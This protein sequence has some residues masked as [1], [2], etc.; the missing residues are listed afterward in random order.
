MNNHSIETVRNFILIG[1]TGRNTGKTTLASA[2]IKKLRERSPVN[3][4]KIITVERKGALCP[5]GGVGCGVCSLE[6][7]F[8]LCEE[9]D[10]LSGKDTAQLLM[11]GANRVFLLRSLK[12]AL[13]GAFAVLRGQTGNKILVAESN[14]L[15]TVVKPALF[16]MLTDGSVRPKFSAQAVMKDA[17]LIISAPFTEN[18]LADIFARLSFPKQQTGQSS[19][20]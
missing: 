1:S 8:V 5:R 10:C 7:D 11:A 16:V 14:S 12:S 19:A 9:H 2:L 4:A 20:D 6:R 15:R 18:D 3:A 13:F 17:D